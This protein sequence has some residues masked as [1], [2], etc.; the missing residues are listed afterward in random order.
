M[1]SPQRGVIVHLDQKAQNES[2][3]VTPIT[4]LPQPTLT[5]FSPWGR[6][7]HSSVPL[8]QKDNLGV[9][10][11]ICGTTILAKGWFGKSEEQTTTTDIEVSQKVVNWRPVVF[12]LQFVFYPIVFLIVLI[13]HVPS[14]HNKI[15]SSGGPEICG[16]LSFIASML[17]VAESY[18]LFFLGCP[19][20][21]EMDVCRSAEIF[22]SQNWV[23]IIELKH[24]FSSL[25]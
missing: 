2:S 7:A 9:K 4:L 13:M 3:L 24:F 12:N 17:S 6:R 22:Y 16:I 14:Q 5:P 18:S 20:L 10:H 8:F 23:T 25:S 19:S 21:A 11:P 1:T 15:S